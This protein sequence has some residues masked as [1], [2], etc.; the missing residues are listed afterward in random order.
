MQHHFDF[1]SVSC[2]AFSNFTFYSYDK[3]HKGATL[4][5]ASALGSILNITH[6]LEPGLIEISSFVSLQVSRQT[7]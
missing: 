3:E 5:W 7:S 2:F 4:A 6:I 1:S